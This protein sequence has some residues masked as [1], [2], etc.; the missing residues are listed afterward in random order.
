MNMDNKIR[1]IAEKYN[2]QNISEIK[3]LNIKSTKELYK[4]VSEKQGGF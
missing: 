2:I 3:K 4:I 1:K